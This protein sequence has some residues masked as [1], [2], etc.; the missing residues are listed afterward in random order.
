M[1]SKQYEA[2]PAEGYD[3]GSAEELARLER[4]CAPTLRDLRTA[5]QELFPGVTVEQE[6]V[7]PQISEEGVVEP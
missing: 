6:G 1:T 3:P 5:A 7:P 4:S 2:R